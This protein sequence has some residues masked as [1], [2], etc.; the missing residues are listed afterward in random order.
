MRRKLKYKPE[1]EKHSIVKKEFKKTIM[2]R[3]TTKEKLVEYGNDNFK[4]LLI[5]INSMNKAEQE[6]NFSFKDRDK[7][8]RDILVH[9]HE[10]HLLLL[11]WVKSN[12]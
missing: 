9:L 2:I 7:N 5:L 3:P 4:K 8:I 10:W 1:I 6:M 11:N 12:G